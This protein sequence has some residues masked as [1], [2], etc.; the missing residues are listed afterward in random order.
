MDEVNLVN[1]A[2]LHW[3]LVTINKYKMFLVLTY[4]MMDHIC[5]HWENINFAV[6]DSY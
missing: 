4:I 2:Y 1:D 6:A 3:A 5:Y